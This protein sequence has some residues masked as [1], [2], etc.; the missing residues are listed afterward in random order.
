MGSISDDVEAI[1]KMNQRI[2]KMIDRMPF[3]LDWV[4]YKGEDCVAEINIEA[5]IKANRPMI[6]ISYC[7]TKALNGVVL[8]TVRWDKK[9]F[10]PSRL[11][12]FWQKL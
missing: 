12:D 2:E 11:G 3:V 1:S 7:M 9:K 5:T 8:K 4:N 6:D 10:K